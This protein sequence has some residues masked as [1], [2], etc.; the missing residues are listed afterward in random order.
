VKNPPKTVTEIAEENNV[1]INKNKTTFVLIAPA[2]YT[3]NIDKP[4]QNKKIKPI[5]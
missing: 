1:D 2:K 4:K 3:A 5:K